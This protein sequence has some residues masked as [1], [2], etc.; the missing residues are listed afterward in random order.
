MLHVHWTLR[1]TRKTISFEKISWNER[2]MNKWIRRRTKSE[3][4]IENNSEWPTEMEIIF[5]Q[6][7]KV[8]SRV[9]YTSEAVEKERN[10]IDSGAIHLTEREACLNQSHQSTI[11]S[12]LSTF[13]H[14]S[15]DVHFRILQFDFLSSHR[16]KYFA[17]KDFD[18]W[19]H[20]YPNIPERRD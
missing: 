14:Y 1:R 12:L 4:F 10:R 5:I 9:T 6:S 19:F 3:Q 2:R 7:S 8:S 17:H 15:L 11:P 16:Y 18:G 20:D 13:H